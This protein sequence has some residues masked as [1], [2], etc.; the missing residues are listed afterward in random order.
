M[1]ATN[2][3]DGRMDEQSTV[4][5]LH[6]VEYYPDLTGREIL[7][8]ATTW[9]N[10]EGLPR[11]EISQTQKGDCCVISFTE[12]PETVKFVESR[13]V[14]PTSLERVEWRDVSWVPRIAVWGDEKVLETDGRDGCTTTCVYLM[15][16]NCT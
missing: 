6:A 7:T 16:L 11:R 14:A 9:M 1:E 12:A 2:V 13:I 15:P 3:G 10:L 4:W 8:Q 5:C